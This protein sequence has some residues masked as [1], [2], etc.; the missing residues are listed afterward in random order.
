MRWRAIERGQ[1]RIDRGARKETLMSQ[2]ADESYEFA[3]G[4]RPALVVKNP[5]GSVT[6]TA[7]AAGRITMQVTRTLRGV[8]MG[9]NGL[10]A[11]ERVRVS[12]EQQQ[13]TVRVTVRQPS[14]SV[15]KH[16][17][18]VALAIEVPAQ[19]R[20]DLEV[21]AGSVEISGVSSEISGRVDAGTLTTRDK[22][23]MDRSEAHSDAG[24]ITIESALGEAASLEVRVDTG[25]A[26]LTLPQW[27]DATL[28]AQVDAGSITIDGWDVEKKR[29]F[30]SVRARGSL[31]PEA[32][33]RLRI[34]GDAGSIRLQAQR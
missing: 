11:F 25:N 26:R 19:C 4:E 6:V 5:A 8:S 20:L 1:R 22:T 29:E 12:A 14:S 31:V 10:E 21:D 34:K 2:R 17:V 33:G 3:V 18:T 24:N 23:F 30:M 15:G 13:E 32:R 9:D 7:G 16:I 27:T 28:D